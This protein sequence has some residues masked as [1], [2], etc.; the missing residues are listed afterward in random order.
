MGVNGEFYQRLLDVRKKPCSTIRD[1][2]L[3]LS[4]KEAGSRI[5]PIEFTS[6][7]RQCTGSQNDERQVSVAIANL[8]YLLPI[9]W[10]GR[11]DLNLRPPEPHSGALPVCATSR[12]RNNISSRYSPVNF[13]G[14]FIRLGTRFPAILT[15]DGKEAGNG[16][17]KRLRFMHKP[18]NFKRLPRTGSASGTGEAT[19]I[20]G[21]A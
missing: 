15:F 16:A 12:Q 14:L 8:P 19:M 18:V 6:M 10:S 2:C 21:R 5:L 9:Y 20:E 3:K 7:H 17:E 1:D 13:L 4:P 11:E